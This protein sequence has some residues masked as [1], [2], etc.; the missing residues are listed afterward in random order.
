MAVILTF[1]IGFLLVWTLLLCF[2]LKP[3]IQHSQLFLGVEPVFPVFHNRDRTAKPLGKIINRYP[4]CQVVLP[5]VENRR[6]AVP[7]GDSVFCGIGQILPR[8]SLPESGRYLP[9][10]LKLL[11]GHPCPAHHVT[12]QLFHIQNGRHKEALFQLGL[13]IRQ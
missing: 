9:R 13:P 8:Q 2:I 6:G 7:F 11:P 3:R 1:F 12:D 10:L 5:G 4:G